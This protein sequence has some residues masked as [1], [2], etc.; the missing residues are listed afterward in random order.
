MEWVDNSSV[1]Q[2]KENYGRHLRL[3]I[4]TEFMAVSSTCRKLWE[5]LAVAVL[6]VMAE[7]HNETYDEGG[8][9]RSKRPQSK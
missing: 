9:Y 2:F 3:D 8:E 7:S 1:G 5:R 6:V 4:R